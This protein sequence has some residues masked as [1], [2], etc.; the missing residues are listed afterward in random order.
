MCKAAFR[1][2]WL[3]MS[4]VLVIIVC[5][6]VVA[7]PEIKCTTVILPL[8]MPR[9][10]QAARCEVCCLQIRRPSDYNSMTMAHL[11]PTQPSAAVNAGLINLS[12]L[13]SGAA[14]ALPSTGG[15]QVR[16]LLHSVTLNAAWTHRCWH[17]DWLQ[18]HA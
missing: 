1:R 18:C 14:K 8:R 2:P 11:G 16:S 13:A 10:A 9:P 5:I 17:V 7:M 4:P 12:G 6:I 15:E 3:K